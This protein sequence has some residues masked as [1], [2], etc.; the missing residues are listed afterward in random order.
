M[1]HTLLVEE[2][3]QAV[4]GGVRLE[5]GV[6]NELGGHCGAEGGRGQ[7]REGGMGK[8]DRESTETTGV[9]GDK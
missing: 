4:V 2:D 6:G 5:L 8:S 9:M 1:R 7:G 3:V